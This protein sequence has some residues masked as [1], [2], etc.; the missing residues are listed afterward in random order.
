MVD[1]SEV[2]YNLTIKY[3]GVTTRYVH[4]YIVI[5]HVLL[6]DPMDCSLAGPLSMEF[7]RQ[8]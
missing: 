1:S 8:E 7:F 3:R 4:V 5:C 2:K 6:C